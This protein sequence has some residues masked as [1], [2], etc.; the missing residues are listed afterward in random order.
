MTL[1]KGSKKHSKMEL[2]TGFQGRNRLAKKTEKCRLIPHKKNSKK[3][4]KKKNEQ[5]FIQTKTD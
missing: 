5:N 1:R 2:K 4:I 3:I